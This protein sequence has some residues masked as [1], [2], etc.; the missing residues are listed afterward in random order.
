[1][2]LYF[3]FGTE[4]IFEQINFNSEPDKASGATVFNELVSIDRNSS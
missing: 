1:M 4:V 2:M 3:K